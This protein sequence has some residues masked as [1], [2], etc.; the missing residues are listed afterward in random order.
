MTGY[1]LK[2]IWHDFSGARLFATSESNWDYFVDYPWTDAPGKAAIW[3]VAKAGSGA[4]SSQFGGLDHVRKLI[5]LGYWD[6]VKLT[7][8]GRQLL[9]TV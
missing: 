2:G 1:N 7:Q 3:A 9:G 8:Y 6:G 4:E 5:R